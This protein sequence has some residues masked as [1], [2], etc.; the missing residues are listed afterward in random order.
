MKAIFGS[1]K[2]RSVMHEMDG[3]SMGTSARCVS[4]MIYR[5]DFKKSQR[6]GNVQFHLLPSAYDTVEGFFMLWSCIRLWFTSDILRSAELLAPLNL[7]TSS[8]FKEQKHEA[9]AEKFFKF[10]WLSGRWFR[11]SGEHSLGVHFDPYGVV[12]VYN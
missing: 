5:V 9:K 6:N 1:L 3:E 10:E 12:V 2:E 11:V 4:W 7:V 8:R